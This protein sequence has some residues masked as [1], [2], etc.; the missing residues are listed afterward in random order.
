MS[1]NIG[2][3]LSNILYHY[4]NVNGVQ[5]QKRACIENAD[6]IDHIWKE[7]IYTLANIISAWVYSYS[8]LQR[9]EQARVINLLT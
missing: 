8:C 3:C 9:T 5:V 6:I 7:A 4:L 2:K 1:E